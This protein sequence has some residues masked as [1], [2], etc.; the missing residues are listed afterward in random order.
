MSHPD[1]QERYLS[2]LT[3]KSLERITYTLKLEL[4]WNNRVYYIFSFDLNEERVKL[5]AK[6]LINQ[7]QQSYFVN[8]INFLA[9]DGRVLSLS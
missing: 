5:I 7:L 9:P 3:V 1:E 8:V 6:D 4:N 2:A